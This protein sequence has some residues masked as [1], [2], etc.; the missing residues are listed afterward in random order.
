MN[1]QNILLVA[2]AAFAAPAIAGVPADEA[3][4]LGVSLT[5]YGAVKAANKEGT[6][7]EYTGGL[8]KAPAGFKAGSG[9]WAD[10]FKDEKPVLRIDGKNYQQYAD[11]LSEGQKELLKKYPT[12]YIDVYPTHRSASIPEKILNNTVRNAVSCKTDKNG[13]ALDESCR[14]GL[15]FPIPK[16]GYE[17]MWNQ[18]LRYKADTTTKSSRSWVVDSN[19]KAVISAQ[20]Q[21]FEETPYYHEHLDGRDPQLY[22]R[23]HSVTQSPVRKAGEATGLMDFMD[24]TVK[25]RRAWSYT[26]GQ[27]RIKLAPEFSY[28]TPVSS[29]G[30]VTL[31][32]ELFV[33]SGQMDRFDFKLVGKKEMYI[34]YNAYKLYFTCG[35]EEQFMDKHPN[36]ACWRWELHRVWVVE[37]TLKP[38]FRHVYNKRIYYFDEDTYGAGLYDAFDQSGQLYRSIFNSM[39]QLYDVQAPYAVKN[40]VYDFNKGMYALVNDGLVGGYGVLTKP[41]SNRELNPEAVVARETAR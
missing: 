32:D 33:F 15:P 31:F 16:T 10:P 20:Q 4:Q 34:P 26:P 13:L 17:V 24:P 6:I 35:V 14:G 3:K 25:P 21:T 40:V 1:I 9:F 30:G 19:G 28:D 39:V 11:K 29:M 41:M 36:P 8:T 18:Q 22:W 27:R 23:T 5:K 37:A 7:P 38:G 12:F 2:V